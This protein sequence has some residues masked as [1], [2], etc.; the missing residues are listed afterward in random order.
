MMPLTIREK[1]DLF[2][3][4]R[5]DQKIVIFRWQ[6]EYPSFNVCDLILF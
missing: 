4:E 3:T 1:L 2:L 6:L 5:A